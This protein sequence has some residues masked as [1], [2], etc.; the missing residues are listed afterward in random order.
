MNSYVITVPRLF[1]SCDSAKVWVGAESAEAA[2]ILLF[3]AVWSRFK[4]GIVLD[5]LTIEERD[6]G[7]FE[8]LI[9]TVILLEDLN[10]KEET[11]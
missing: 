1:N 10:R 7:W 2:V 8:L 9:G 5:Q 11:V 6:P 4:K 3:D